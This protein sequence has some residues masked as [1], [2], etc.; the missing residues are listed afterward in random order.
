MRPLPPV[1]A[2]ENVVSCGGTIARSVIGTDIGCPA[3]G[4][5]CTEADRSPGEA[6]SRVCTVN[7]PVCPGRSLRKF[8]SP[9]RGC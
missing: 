6:G 5:N 1:M 9:C 3:D 2:P 8:G 7:V 4:V